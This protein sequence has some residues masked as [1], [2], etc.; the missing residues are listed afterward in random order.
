MSEITNCW[1][2]AVSSESEKFWGSEITNC[3]RGAVSSES[4]KFWGSEITNCWRGLVSSV[5]EVLGERDNELLERGGF[6]SQRSSG[7]VR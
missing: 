5:R 6:L 7:G 3:W 1:R 4:E 2:G